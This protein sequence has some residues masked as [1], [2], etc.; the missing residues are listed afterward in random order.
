MKLAR[1]LLMLM[2]VMLVAFAVTACGNDDDK[3]DSKDSKTGIKKSASF[4]KPEELVNYYITNAE[5]LQNDQD[6][7]EKQCRL[8]SNETARKK[9]DI[10]D[11]DDDNSV[12]TSWE[13]KK[14]KE[15]KED[16][17][18]TD[19][20]K[21]YIR[22]YDGDEDQVQGSAITE[23]L[24]TIERGEEKDKSKYYIT[25]VKIGGKWYVI[26]DRYADSLN[27]MADRWSEI[28]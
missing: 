20:V 5:Q 15:Y 19:G 9:L 2:L 4:S 13:I 8:F 28:R 3:K 22:N 7:L 24:I 25:S 18:V 17:D 1:R 6:N 21:V 14:T 26:D 11:E 10:Y 23:V 27:D 16:D 12:K